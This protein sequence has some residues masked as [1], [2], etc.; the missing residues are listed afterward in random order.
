M[1]L[2]KLTFVSVEFDASADLKKECGCLI[3]CDFTTFDQSI[4]TATFPAEVYSTALYSLGFSDFKYVFNIVI[5]MSLFTTRDVNIN[6]V[7]LSST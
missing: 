6:S 7:S 2:Y 1:W 4:S 3:S 5:S